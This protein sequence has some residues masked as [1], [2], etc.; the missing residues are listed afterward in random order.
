MP[1]I[2]A[3]TVAEHRAAQQR[4][5]LDAAKTLLAKTG[6]APSMAEVAALAG[7]ARPSAYQYYKSRTDLLNALVLDVFPRWARRVEDAMAAEELPA[8]RILAYVMTNITLVAEGEHAVGSALAAVAPGEELDTQSNRMHQALLDPLVG[9]LTEM[10]S[11][12]P[13]STAELINAIVHS[14]TRLLESGKTLQDVHELVREL[15]GPFVR[16]HGGKS[17]AGAR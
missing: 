15:L 14:G 3:P 5:L 1:R 10:G 9:A 13:A 7:L 16:E 6:E 4:A 12:D 11:A 8:D 17:R 2:T